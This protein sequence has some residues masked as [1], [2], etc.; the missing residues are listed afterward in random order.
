MN[1]YRGF[2]GVSNNLKLAL[3]LFVIFLV[4]FYFIFHAITGEN[5]LFSY[6]IVKKKVNETSV[7]LENLTRERLY[8]ENNVRLLSR[9]TLDLDILEERCRI[10]LNYAYPNEIIVKR[11]TIISNE[12]K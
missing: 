7:K 2:V 3:E 4:F 6:L 11:K 1:I 12:G 10:I 5:G 8:L 9:Q